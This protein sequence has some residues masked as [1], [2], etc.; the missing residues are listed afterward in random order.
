[1]KAFGTAVLVLLRARDAQ[2]RATMCGRCDDD[3]SGGRAVSM[4]REAEDSERRCERCG[5]RRVREKVSF[6][7]PLRQEVRRRV[8]S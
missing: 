3:T 4:S 1:M 7:C 2:R 8:G 5:V 6:A